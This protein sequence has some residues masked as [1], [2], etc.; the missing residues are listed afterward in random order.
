MKGYRQYEE[1]QVKEAEV[2]EAEQNALDALWIKLKEVEVVKDTEWRMPLNYI[3]A[4]LI[5]IAGKGEAQVAVDGEYYSL[6]AGGAI[7]CLPNQLV[8]AVVEGAED[9]EL[10]ILRYDVKFDGG[11]SN[12]D[13]SWPF[14]GLV[15]LS[16]HAKIVQSCESI[17]KL[18][19]SGDG[20]QR[21]QSQSLFHEIVH[22]ILLDYSLN[23]RAMR[24]PYTLVQTKEHMELHYNQNITIDELAELAGVSRYHYMRSFK[25]AFGISAIDYLLELR[26]SQSK[27]LM[28]RTDIRLQAV[29]ERV[30]YQDEYYFARKFKQIVGIPPATYMKSRKRRIAA[31]SFPNIGQ[32]LPLRIVPYAAP[33]DHY[34]TDIYRRKYESD[35]VVKL[36]HHYEFNW[37]ALQKAEPDFIIGVDDFTIEDEQQK[38]K[39][40]APSLFVPW[41]SANWRE[42]MRLA[43]EFLGN[44]AEYAAWMEDYESKVVKTAHQ[45][46]GLIRSGPV[47]ML[48][49]QQGKIYAYGNRS[50]ASLL[51]EDL[52]FIAP[53]GLS[54]IIHTR[55]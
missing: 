51:Y 22:R 24:A 11:D 2:R 36:S 33:M 42:H 18:W 38:L 37:N 25:R 35:V 9:S 49:L 4:Y 40:I 16:E 45:I 27:R 10:C 34:W 47:L 26:I 55:S 14:Y 39:N 8:S 7:V 31:Y 15:E 1:A 32:L 29:A 41:S 21:F 50:V 43:A 5:L 13:V 12:A 54:L 3:T 17:V 30:G 52:G 19:G 6:A 28:E 20:M 46:E 48:Q 44:E 23:N 53:R